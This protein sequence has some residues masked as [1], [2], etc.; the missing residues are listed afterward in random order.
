MDI[1]PHTARIG[2]IWG[3]HCT[4]PG[5]HGDPHA[6][7]KLNIG[8]RLGTTRKSSPMAMVTTINR[9]IK[10]KQR[11]SHIEGAI[12]VPIGTYQPMSS[13]ITPHTGQLTQDIPM[14]QHYHWPIPLAYPN[15]SA[16][17]HITRISI[18]NSNKMSF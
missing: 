16:Q 9:A 2:T 12:L 5:P 7:T 17:Q 13:S 6:I 4:Q 8:P 15:T 11:F 14:F 18:V 3:T 10:P 1:G